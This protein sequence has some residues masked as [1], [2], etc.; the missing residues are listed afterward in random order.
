MFN[1]AFDMESILLGKLICDYY[2]DLWWKQRI[3]WYRLFRPLCC[4]WSSRR[5]TSIGQFKLVLYENSSEASSEIL[6]NTWTEQFRGLYKFVL[7]SMFRTTS[8][9]KTR[10]LQ[11]KSRVLDWS[12]SFI[13]LSLFFSFGIKLFFCI[14]KLLYTRLLSI[15]DIKQIKKNIVLGTILC[16]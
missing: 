12:F 5:K 9:P 8:V 4:F 7:I 15:S 11:R 2:P 6:N 16:I 14:L 3:N 1:A 13:I 10:H